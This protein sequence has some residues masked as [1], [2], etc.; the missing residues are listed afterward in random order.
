MPRA[1]PQPPRSARSASPP[2]VSDPA[3]SRALGAVASDLR[4]LQEAPLAVLVDGSRPPE[5][6]D[7]APGDLWYRDADGRLARLP[8]GQ[9]GQVLTMVGGLPT[10]V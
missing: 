9:D 7:D 8:A 6:G 3:T 5:L 10:W 2:R 4:A 1:R